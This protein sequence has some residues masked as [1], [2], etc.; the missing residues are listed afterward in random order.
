MPWV[1]DGESAQAIENTSTLMGFTID[2]GGG[3]INGIA[4]LSVNTKGAATGTLLSAVRFAAPRAVLAGDVLQFRY[5]LQ[6]NA[7]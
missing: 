4:I 6:Y 1:Q 3:T 5:K 2:V 7:G